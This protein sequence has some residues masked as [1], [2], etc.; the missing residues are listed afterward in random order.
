MDDFLN[1]L[2]DDELMTV[3]GGTPNRG[4]SDTGGIGGLDYL[5][6][7]AAMT[8]DGPAGLRICPDR[9][10]KTTAWPASTLLACTWDP[11]VIFRVGEA[12]AKEVRENNIGMWLAPAINIHRNP[13]C[14]RNFEYYSEDPL[15]AGELASAMVQGIQSQ[16]VSAC[17]KHFCCNN[18]ESYRNISD[19]RVS[20][21][22]LRE[23]YLKAFEIVVKHGGVWSIM[24]S[25][26]LLNGV[27]TSEN[28]ELLTGILREEW[29]YDG[30][31]ITDWWNRGEHYREALAG[32][33]VRMPNGSPKRLQKAMELGLITRKELL[34]NAKQVLNWLLKLN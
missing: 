20:E 16:R 27:Y 7:P 6:V 31:V 26:N 1:R 34:T 25:Y 11:K 23:I 5:G 21:R 24:T 14:A 4:V 29:G 13:L 19:S 30:L 10:I 2:T 22:A 15:V 33:N 17:V 9:G 3:I 28:E 12:A 32:N 18:K 8:A